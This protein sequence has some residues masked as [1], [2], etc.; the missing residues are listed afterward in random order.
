MRRALDGQ[1]VAGLHLHRSSGEAPR[2]W[3]GRV[4]LE[5]GGEE[6]DERLLIRDRAMLALE[7]NEDRSTPDGEHIEPAEVELL[8]RIGLQFDAVGRA[9]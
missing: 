6:G 2:L 8:I 3:Q 7:V 9:R 4:G 1:R 5:R